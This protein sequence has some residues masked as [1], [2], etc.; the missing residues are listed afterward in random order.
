MLE[1]IY[2]SFKRCYFLD[3]FLLAVLSPLGFV[4][5]DGAGD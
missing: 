4:D 5:A 1:K 3:P 2:T